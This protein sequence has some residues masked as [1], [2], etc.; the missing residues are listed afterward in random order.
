MTD[1]QALPD[2][3]E[4]TPETVPDAPRVRVI[5]SLVEGA[6]LEAALGTVERQDYESVAQVVVVGIEPELPEG[7]ESVASVADA[8]SAAEADVDYVWLLHS[9]ARPRPDALSALVAEVERSGASLGGSKILIAGSSDVLESIGSATDVFGEPYS[10]LD[11]GEIDLQQYDVVREVATVSGVSMLIRRD[12]AQGL[13]GADEKLAPGAAGLDLSQ[14]ARIAGGRVVIVPSSEVY[15][16]GKCGERSGGWQEEAGRMRAMFK[17]YSLLT[18]A[19]VLPF[20]LLVALLD[21]VTSLLLLRWRPAASHVASIG[22]NVVHLPSSIGERRRLG[23]VRAVGDEELFRFQARGSIRLRQVGSELSDKVLFMFDDDQALARGTRRVWAS[24]GIWGAFLAAV[25]LVFIARSIL[26]SGVPN[27]GFSFPFEPPTIAIDRFLGG[28][29][30]S[31]LGSPAPSHPA[32]GITG[33]ASL[34]WFGTEGAARTLLTLGAGLMAIV[35][36]GRL[37]G[38]LGFRGPG[39]YL[40]GLV[41]LAGPGTALLVGSGSWLGLAGAAFLPWSVRSV[42]LH[43]DDLSKSWITH[44]SWTLFWT[45][46]VAA[47]SPLLIVVPLIASVLWRVGGGRRTR[48]FLALGSLAGAVAGAAFVIGDPGWVADSDRRLGLQVPDLWPV[49]VAAAG[50]LV[51][52]SSGRT[53]RLAG[54]GAILSLGSLAGLVAPEL[55]P[56][57]EEAL[58]IT[59]SFGAAMVVAAAL[60]LGSREPVK[61]LA[62]L[63][64]LVIVG[65]SIGATADGRLGLPEG[66]DN[67]RYGFASTL[68]AEGGAGRLLV[69][70][71]DQSLI[72][73]EA[74][75]GSGYWYRVI[76][77]E[78]VTLDEVWLPDPLPGDGELDEDLTA[79]SSGSELRPGSLLAPYSIDWLVIVGEPVYLEEI[80]EAQVDLIPTP[81]DPS[82]HVYENPASLPLA[83]EGDETWSRDGTGFAGSAGSGRARISVNQDNGWAP[84]PG[85]GDWATTVSAATG[86]ARFTASGAALYLPWVASVLFLVAVAGIVLARLRR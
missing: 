46:I 36:M 24:P 79:I 3:D 41:L 20:G 80:L 86:E 85:S 69:I 32:T 9:D 28:W 70:S 84:D 49:L 15:H 2:S 29:N 74:R 27:V 16:Q 43:E 12:L 48:W 56:G 78:G 83:F 19:W 59:A 25:I 44:L 33:L 75:P 7:V 23:R 63:V 34:L 5:V 50:I 22:W 62:A 10:G 6:N 53:R 1:V 45:L 61:V 18:L 52:L 30:E 21:S 39:R 8:I 13:G 54:V 65:L 72:P 60:D 11:E 55:G 57:A 40:S 37:A 58:L 73:G 47:F 76:D 66:D 82:S 81:L 14:R 68:A 31:G 77:G 17:A 26:F 71:T 4:Q 35:G 38:R 64:G 67:E 42:F 51:L